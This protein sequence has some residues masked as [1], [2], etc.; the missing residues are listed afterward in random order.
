M[1]QLTKEY[2]DKNLRQ[3]NKTLDRVAKTLD[4][5]VAL[6]THV[7][8]KTDHLTEKVDHIE[9]VVDDHTKTLDAILKNSKDWNTEAEALRSAIR[10]H[11]EWITQIANKVG[12]KLSEQ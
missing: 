2:F 11:E 7:A 12:I 10:R 5:T 8:E 1:A 3:T 4:R 6:L 9:E